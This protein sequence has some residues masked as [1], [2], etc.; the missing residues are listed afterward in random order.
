MGR[1]VGLLGTVAHLIDIAKESSWQALESKIELQLF[2]KFVE[3]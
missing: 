3:M 2:Q 1:F